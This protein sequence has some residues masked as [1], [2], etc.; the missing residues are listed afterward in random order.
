M[1][2]VYQQH[3]GGNHGGWNNNNNN[4]SNNKIELSMAAPGNL[5][6]KCWNCNK[7]V[8]R[9]KECQ[10]PSTNNKYKPSNNGNNSNGNARSQRDVVCDECGMCGHKHDRCFCLA[11]NAHR[12]PANWCPPPG[13]RGSSG[14]SGEEQGQATLDHS[15]DDCNGY[16]LMMCQLTFAQHKDLLH[17]PNIIWLGDFGASTHSTAYQNGMVNMVD[18]TSS[19]GIVVENNQVNNVESIG[20]VPGVF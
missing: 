6:V 9:S 12:R 10:S 1:E 5:A 13:Y 2:V 20:D 17:D 16:E 19:D 8:H 15:G 7:N 4:N 18:A 11:A 14:A 3:G